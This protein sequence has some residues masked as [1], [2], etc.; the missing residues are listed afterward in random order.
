MKNFIDD[1]KIIHVVVGDKSLGLDS[2]EIG[3]DLGLRLE[4]KMNF[5]VVLI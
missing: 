1:E 2:I 4:W 3:L 5:I